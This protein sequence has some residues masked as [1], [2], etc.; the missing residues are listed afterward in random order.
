MRPLTDIVAEA[1]RRQVVTALRDAARGATAAHPVTSEGRAA[2]PRWEIL[3][4]VRA[5]HRRP[6]RRPSRRGLRHL[7]PRRLGA[8]RRRAPVGRRPFPS[9][10]HPRLDGRRDPRPRQR[11]SHHRLQRALLGDLAHRRELRRGGRRLHQTLVRPRS[12]PQPAGLPGAPQ[13]APGQAGAGE[14]RHAWSSRTGAPSNCRPGRRR[15]AAPSSVGSGAS[16]TSPIASGW[17]TSW[18]TGPSTTP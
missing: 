6:H 16:A 17:R 18:S 7:G 8:G 9:H 14:L 1:D 13:G 15:W 4:S 12:A 2:P 3:G 5:E 10:R 11:R